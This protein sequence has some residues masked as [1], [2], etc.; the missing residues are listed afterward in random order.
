MPGAGPI[1]IS[2]SD[3][4]VKVFHSH[5][6][7]LIKDFMR[8]NGLDQR[9]DVLH[10]PPGVTGSIPDFVITEKTSGK[11]V[12]VI[13]MKRTP[14]TVRSI[15]T[16]DQARSYVMNNKAIHWSVSHKPFFLVTNLELSYFLCD[17]PGSSAQFCLLKNGERSC[18]V[19]GGDATNTL[20]QFTDS[21]IKDIFNLIDSQNDIYSDNLKTI[22]ADFV[23][24]QDQL[25]GY[26][27]KTI[28]AKIKSTPKK[29]GFSSYQDFEDS[30]MEWKRLNDP[31]AAKLDFKKVA[32]DI[33]RD[34]MLRIFTYEYCREY[35][36]ILGMHKS[37]KPISKS[38]LSNL[39]K[40]IALSFTDLGK[41]DFS[42][43][44]RDRMMQFVP[45]NMDNV[46]FKI[47]EA[48]LGRV[49]GD[50]SN[51]IKE[52]GSP[53]YLLNLI[54]KDEKFYPWTEANGDG[55]VM[56]DPELA[57]MVASICMD[58]SGN[59]NPPDIF[60]PGCGTS[61]LLSSVYER[62]RSKYPSMT[63]DQVLSKLH[64]CEVDKFLGK[65]GVLHLILHS[66]KEITKKTEVD[67]RLNDFFET[68]KDERGKYDA[69]I[70][71]PPFIRNDNKVAKLQRSTIETKIKKAIGNTSFMAS[72]SQ[73][74]YFFYFVEMA[75]HI[76]RDGGVGAYFINKSV[77]N[78]ENGVHFKKFLL[79]NYD[80]HYVISCPRIFFEGYMV[81]PCIIIGK[82]NASSGKNQ[83]IKFAR[84]VDPKFF[85]TDYQDLTGQQN[86]GGLLR[87]VTV[88]QSTISEDN[89][90]KKFTMLIPDFYEIMMS[91]DAFVP[92]GKIFGNMKRGELAN[93]NN[94]SAFFFPWSNREA[95][96]KLRKEISQI[97]GEFKGLGLQNA[98]IPENY[99]L[100]SED[101]HKQECL[102]VP[103][104][105]NVKAKKGL[106]AFI[107]KFDTVFVRPQR[108]QIDSYQSKAEIVIPR[109]SR[110]THAVFLNP[111]WSSQ[112][113]YFSSNFVCFW[114]LLL[115][116]ER[117]SKDDVLKFVAAF[118]N[119]S[120]GQIAFE[121]EC[122]DREGLRKIEAG[123]MSSKIIVPNFPLDSYA[124]DVANVIKEF[125]KLPFGLTG[126]ESLPS[127]RREL[128]IAIA[129]TLM[130]IE[131]KFASMY[132]TPEE[133][134]DSAQEA[135]R[136]IVR[137]R[138]EI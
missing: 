106:D 81:S 7:Q 55:K 118:L 12:F 34:S 37:L 63:H 125:K 91:S 76:L 93:V 57:E 108:W 66:P 97:E 67:I 25:A 75:T 51:A 85:T 100:S 49:H 54:T 96:D 4:E 14:N 16:W 99:S 2:Y 129:Q 112:N 9:Y 127:P 120:F 119:S 74:N 60:D 39:E 1:V 78:T 130:K 26:L 133:F 109:M 126:L 35:F 88:D 53:A 87:I 121:A 45:E 89:D 15:R 117:F 116:S 132:A 36:N 72:S 3:D 19:F 73:P 77:L 114:D 65:L 58:L 115:A 47:L 21:V 122:Q 31:R 113:V 71:N 110:E 128:D 104:S 28:L 136:E 48:F 86:E 82:K 124:G 6:E 84:I 13:E 22:L 50:I 43:I 79:K 70:M 20:N 30:L 131:P 44:I 33:A 107:R 42:Q 105:V 40:S 83:K 23:G 134:A 92:V 69:V 52:N 102:A 41:I 27:S 80:I 8:A 123:T 18:P 111:F 24:L 68:C 10:H 137:D 101:L 90:W 56:T 64:G 62:I 11:W 29:F 94:G 17:R 138:C 59:E 38:N 95:N 135:L 46:T 32:R 98:D 61:N 5:F 103:A